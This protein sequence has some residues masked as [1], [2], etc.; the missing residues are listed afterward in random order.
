LQQA[1]HET[2]LQ[3]LIDYARTADQTAAKP[4][5]KMLHDIMDFLAMTPTDTL[6]IGDTVSDM[7]LAANAGVDAVAISHY[8][9]MHAQ[10]RGCNPALCIENLAQLHQ[11]LHANHG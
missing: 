5:P 7:Q 8:H 10:L 2:H 9:E 3:S 4:N 6:M 11:W 1:L